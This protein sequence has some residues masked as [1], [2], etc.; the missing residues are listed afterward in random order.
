MRPRPSDDPVM[1]TR[2]TPTPPI[3]PTYPASDPEWSPGRQ[4]QD[5]AAINSSRRTRQ[6]PALVP[7]FEPTGAAVSV[8]RHAEM[9]RPD[10]QA[11]FL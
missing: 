6:I 1:N 5:S 4:H 8:Q 9:V 2:A 10:P 3:M 11:V 7:E